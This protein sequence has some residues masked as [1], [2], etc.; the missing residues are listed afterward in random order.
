MENKNVQ[1]LSLGEN[2]IF[3]FGDG[4][5][6]VRCGNIKNC[7]FVDFTKNGTI[8][9]IWDCTNI[10]DTN[11]ISKIVFL[12]KNEKSLDDLIGVLEYCKNIYR[13]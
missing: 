3:E 8:N 13:K 4:S 7:V 5:I 11:Y 9:K 2:N 6:D 12:F 1:T 10:S